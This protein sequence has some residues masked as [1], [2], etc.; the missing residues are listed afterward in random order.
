[1]VMAMRRCRQA[2]RARD[3]ELKGR[4]GATR[5]FS[6]NQEPYRERPETDGLVGRIDV[7]ADGLLCHVCIFL[8]N[9]V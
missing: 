5:V 6:S 1:M 8:V 7:E 3:N 2:L 4:D 9:G